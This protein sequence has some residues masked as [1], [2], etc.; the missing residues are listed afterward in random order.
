MMLS[1]RGH[2]VGLIQISDAKG[3]AELDRTELEGQWIHELCVEVICAEVDHV[4]G[5]V[6]GG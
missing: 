2:S 6:D 3:A 1:H 4:E 5:T